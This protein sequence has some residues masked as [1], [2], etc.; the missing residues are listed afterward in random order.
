MIFICRLSIQIGRSGAGGGGDAQ[1]LILPRQQ[2]F[3]AHSH[4]GIFSSFNSS[5]EVNNFAFS[6]F[7]KK[8]CII[9]F[10]IGTNKKKFFKKFIRLQCI[11]KFLY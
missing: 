3:Y 6:F 4:R 11:L 2:R 1:M 9:L 10:F 5:F 8:T 7:I